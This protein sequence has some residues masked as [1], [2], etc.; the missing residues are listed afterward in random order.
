M[1]LNLITID[2]NLLPFL[3]GLPLP[4]LTWQPEQLTRLKTGPKPSKLLTELGAVVQDLRKRCLPPVNRRILDK[5]NEGMGAE[6]ASLVSFFTDISASIGKRY[7]L[8]LIFLV[9]TNKNISSR[10]KNIPIIDL[11]I[12]R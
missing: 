7:S 8:L 2:L 6:K 12:R 1:R 10:R 4:S 9:K 5:L 3:G 11:F